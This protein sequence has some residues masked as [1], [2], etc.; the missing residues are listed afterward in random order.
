[1]RGVATTVGIM[2]GRLSPLSPDGPQTFPAGSWREEYVRAADFGFDTLEWL[3]EARSLT[4]NP[5]LD[6][7]GRRAMAATTAATGVQVTSL[8][9]HFLVEWAPF[10]TGAA[11]QARSMLA[12]VVEAAAAAGMNRIVVPLVEGASPTVAAT[13]GAVADLLLP[14]AALAAA[15]GLRL[16]LETDL[17]SRRLAALLSTLDSPAIQVCY[18][19]GNATAQGL[20]IV[21]DARPLLASIAEIHVKDRKIGG[22]TGPLGQGDTR[23]ADFAAL[24]REEAW[25]GPFVLETPVGDDYAMAARHNLAVTRRVFGEG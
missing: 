2:Q 7:G 21:A 14:A 3:V 20:D 16:C 19:I 1:M 6:E 22:A 17:E 9:A 13:P 10:T 18:D 15:A 25:R 5:L 12:T 8:C 24:L 4:T 23:L 11:G